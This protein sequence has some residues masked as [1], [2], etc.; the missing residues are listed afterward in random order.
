MLIQFY[1]K[2]DY[3]NIYYITHK[4]AMSSMDKNV[5][6]LL[7]KER[8]RQRKQQI[9]EAQ[10]SQIKSLGEE[11]SCRL[12]A[13]KIQYLLG[14]PDEHYSKLSHIPKP[15]GLWTNYTN[16][17]TNCEEFRELKDEINKSQNVRLVDNP[18]RGFVNYCVRDVDTK[19]GK[20][21]YKLYKNNL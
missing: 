20:V 10:Q 7:E 13:I 14:H 15:T 17:S 5:Q 2:I 6:I 12:L 4:P 11:E 8:D 18:N 16:Y 1:N 9:F 3:I 19:E 21:T